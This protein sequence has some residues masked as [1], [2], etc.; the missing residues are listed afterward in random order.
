MNEMLDKL[1]VAFLIRLS[2]VGQ[3]PIGVRAG[4]SG[5]FWTF[6]SLVYRFSAR[7]RLKYCLNGPL[8]P[9]QPIN[10]S[11]KGTQQAQNLSHP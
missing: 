4:M 3:G 10:I 9:K 6:F 7:Y 2:I 5:F 11:L 8:N 1:S